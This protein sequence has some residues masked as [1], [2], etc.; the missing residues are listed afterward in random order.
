M[1]NPIYIIL[2]LFSLH[3]CELKK[4]IS[5]RELLLKKI[6]AFNFLQDFHPQLHIMIGEEEGDGETAYKTFLH[7][8]LETKNDEIIPVINA[9]KRIKEYKKNKEEVENLDYL[10]DYYQSGL[11]LQIESILRGYGYLKTFPSD[12]ALAIY[13]RINW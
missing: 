5:E 10:V 11:S 6:E 13:D 12:S 2:F 4:H 7:A 8:L 3:S 1:K 9:A